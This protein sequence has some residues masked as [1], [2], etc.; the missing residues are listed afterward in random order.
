MSNNKLDSQ[1]AFNLVESRRKKESDPPVEKKG[2]EDRFGE[3]SARALEERPMWKT[4]LILTLAALMTVA[5]VIGLV[6]F[7]WFMVNEAE[8]VVAE[9]GP[10]EVAPAVIDKA[11]AK[12]IIEDNLR[13]F[14]QAESN[15]ERLK[16]IYMPED[17]ISS[18]EDYYGERQQFETP[19]W[20]IDRM[21][22]MTSIQGETWFVGYRDVKKTKHFVS[23]QRYGD[24][25]LLHWSAMTAY[26]ELPWSQFLTERPITPV[27]MRGYLRHYEGVV[28]LSIDSNVDGVFLFEDPQKLVSEL[29][30]VGKNI[31]GYG[32]LSRLRSD[33]SH[34]VTAWLAYDQLQTGTEKLTLRMTKLKYLR[35]QQAAADPRIEH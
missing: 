10:V 17:E 18:L 20:K 31:H 28:P 1:Q 14:L 32:A 4:Y 26:G 22:L 34:P 3:D 6:A 35:W 24:N 27:L 9:K 7:Y 33:S 29:I 15:K 5:L 30:V 21:D 23:F 11:D 12:K 2:L 8:P 13:A 19:L 25:Y 16:Y